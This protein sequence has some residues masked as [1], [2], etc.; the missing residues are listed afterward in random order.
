MRLASFNLENL[1]D[2]ARALNL[3][4]WA[5]GREVLNVFTRVSKLLGK[6]RYSA[7][8]KRAIVEGL[9]DLGVAKRDDGGRFVVLRQNKGELVKRSKGKATVVAQGR[10]DWVGWLELRVEPVDEIATRNTAQVVRD[11]GADVLAVVEAESRVALAR[12]NE[13]ILAA[14]GAE[15]YRHTMLID[16]NDE[17]GIDVGILTRAPHPIGT[18]RSH[19]DDRDA[20]GRIFSRD[21]PEYEVAL[22]S[23]E[24]LVVL[25]NHLKSKGYGSQSSSDAR[26][27]RQA[28]RAR[29]IYD[30]RRAQGFD[31]VAVVGDF[32]DT[33][34]SAALAP[35]LSDGS[36]LLDVSRHSNYLDDGRPGTF[37]NGT[38]S[39]KIDYILCSQPLFGQVKSAGVFRTGV[40]GGKNGTLWEIYPEMQKPAHAASDHAAIWADLD[41]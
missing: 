35:L 40:W 30:A 31:L 38:K 33:P 36:D 13:Q 17:R 28:R 9:G 34:D 10:E 3:E 25:V 29:E 5:E 24:R 20:S 7:A 19:V 1:F 37:G 39:G 15:P 6:A 12:F 41:V 18:M 26:R 8:D 4:S 16:G 22:P 2:R 11:V 23:G 32:N 14:A 21:C 27:M